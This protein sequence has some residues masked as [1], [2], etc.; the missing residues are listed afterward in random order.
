MIWKLEDAK[1][2]R[3][4]VDL[5]ESSEILAVEITRPWP[6]NYQTLKN[7][8]FAQLCAIRL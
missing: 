6:E 3:E 8:V 1:N 5:I 4:V 7:H 2:R